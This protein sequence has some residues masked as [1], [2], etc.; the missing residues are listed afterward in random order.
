MK[1]YFLSMCFVFLTISN[2]NSATD[3]AEVTARAS[4]QV[5]EVVECENPIMNFGS[6]AVKANNEE[7]S[8]AL[9]ANSTTQNGDVVAVNNA[10][11]ATCSNQE[12]NWEAVGDVTLTN[13]NGKTV[14]ITDIGVDA[15]NN[16]TGNLIIPKNADSGEYV[17]TFTV[18]SIK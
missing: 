15:N 10:S 17:G 14:T 12:L 16:V 18:A 13:N 1:K 7:S 9:G 6:L 3:Y 8:V 11:T 4:I 2:V 5:A